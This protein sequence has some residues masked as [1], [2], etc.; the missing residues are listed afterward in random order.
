MS[1]TRHELEF[2][3]P[4]GKVTTFY[5]QTD[6]SRYVLSEHPENQGPHV[7]LVA[8][9]YGDEIVRNNLE[10]NP[11]S[12]PEQ[13]Q[14]Y[15]ERLDGRFDQWEARTT[16]V[17][18]ISQQPNRVE[19]QASEWQWRNAHQLEP[20]ELQNKLGTQLEHGHQ[21]SREPTWQEEMLNS[22][23][24]KLS[25]ASLPQMNQEERLQEQRQ[26]E[27]RQQQQRRHQR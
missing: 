5:M 22:I 6:G 25:K 11:K 3:H 9:R 15:A 26:E 2:D 7:S 24:E 21:S 20:Q 18:D 14:L 8:S 13:A 1:W 23:H 10:V 19:H 17:Q 27:Q 16:R 4:D 12:Q